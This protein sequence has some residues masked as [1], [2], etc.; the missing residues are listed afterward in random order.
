M[1]ILVIAEHEKGMLRP[2]SRNALQFA[3]EVA[4]ELAA[5]VTMLVAGHETESAAEDAARYAPTIRIDTEHLVAP[6]A[7]RLAPA[8]AEVVRRSGVDMVVAATSA[9]SKDILGRLG[10]LLGGAMAGDV[11]GHE[12]VDGT[13][14]FRRPMFAG[15]LV[16]TMV[17]KGSPQVV[18]VRSSAYAEAAALESP[19]AVRVMDLSPVESDRGVRFE[20]VGAKASGRPDATEA[21]IVVSGG[22][23]FKTADDFEQKVGALA[24]HLGAAVGCSRALVDAGIAPN[25]WQIGQTGKIVAPELYLALGLSGA[26]QHLAGMNSSK[27]IAAVNT[28]REAPIFSVADYG[29]VGNVH[30]VVPELLAKLPKQS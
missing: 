9:W 25:E 24:D 7:D 23:A 14:R 30:E 6:L 13:V 11:V 28:D 10:G 3:R 15:E 19:Q 8:L 21:R 4:G 27:V 26:I 12:V 5:E 20:G 16:A 29:L 17:L 18:T 1:K 22:R 2:S